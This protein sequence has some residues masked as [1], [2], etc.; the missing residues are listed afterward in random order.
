M[1]DDKL[2][3]NKLVLALDAPPKDWKKPIG[4]KNSNLSHYQ[5]HNLKVFA[6]Q[7]KDLEGLATIEEVRKELA[8]RIAHGPDTRKTMK[9][10]KG[11][12]V[13]NPNYGKYW[14]VYNK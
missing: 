3:W 11:E 9:N 10:Y 2:Q 8:K 1:R 12:E 13:A 4:P 6:D 14:G 7:G 5:Y